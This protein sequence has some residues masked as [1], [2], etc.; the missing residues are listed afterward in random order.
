M[1]KNSNNV[2]KNVFFKERIYPVLFM[3]LVTIVSITLVSGIYLATKPVIKLNESLFL[4]KA[5]LYA[6]G[7]PVPQ[8]TAEIDDAYRFHVKEITN[9][10]GSM[11]HFEIVNPSTGET[12][13]FV[14]FASGPGLWGEITALIGFDEQNN[15][16]TGIE[17]IKQNETPGLGGRITE[18][19]FKEQFRLRKGPFVLVSE[20]A[21]SSGNELNAI[22]GASW[23]S[24]YVLD[25]VNQTILKKGKP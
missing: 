9:P 6:A 25:L 23:T 20:D 19:W 8:T 18:D 15:L 17:F 10:D 12:E 21:Q 1:K 7:I 24:G 5:V 4:K 16:I 3:M 11:D 13:G 22:T 14:Y 2:F